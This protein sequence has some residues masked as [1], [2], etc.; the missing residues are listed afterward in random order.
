MQLKKVIPSA[1]EFM[2]EALIILGGA[3][4][5]VFLSDTSLGVFVGFA[6][7]MLFSGLVF[8]IYR[9]AYRSGRF[10]LLNPRSRSE[11]N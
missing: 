6:A 3:A 4:L 1:P 9:K 10:D 2:R 11:I 8:V 5:A 7:L